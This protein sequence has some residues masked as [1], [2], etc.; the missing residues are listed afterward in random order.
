M[1]LKHVDFYSLDIGNT[2]ISIGLHFA[3]QLREIIPYNRDLNLAPVPF[4]ISQVAP[5]PEGLKKMIV[6][7]PVFV[8]DFRTPNTF[9]DMPVHYTESL[10]EDRLVQAYYLFKNHVSK[11]RI[12]L[13]DAGSFITTDFISQKG[14]EGGYIVPGKSKVQNLFS[15]GFNL[16][17][18]S[19]H[20]RS[21]K[22]GLP[23]SS[24][25]A[26]G[27]GLHCLWKGF[28]NQMLEE[29]NPTEVFV[30][31]GDSTYFQSFFKGLISFREEKYLIHKSLGFLGEYALNEYLSRSNRL[32]SS[33]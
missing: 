29:H 24:S 26:M 7:P 30:T 15:D 19:F 16:R 21:L 27:T 31:G 14:F 11:N 6:Y 4:V 3:G 32:D 23:A 2:N 28:L 10:G 18:F 5:I 8:S 12:L 17:D 9:I 13:I 25:E 33:L 22:S 1:N 20:K